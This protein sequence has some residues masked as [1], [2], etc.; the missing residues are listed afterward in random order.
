MKELY[1]RLKL[2]TGVSPQALNNTNT[3]GKYFNTAMHRKLLIVLCGAAMAATKTTKIEM[4]QAT[5]INGTGAKAVTNA[6]ATITA[7]TNVDVATIDLTNVANTDKITING[8][9][10][11]KAAATTVASKEF[12]NAA[13]LVSCVNNASYGVTGIKATAA[14]EVVTVEAGETGEKTITATPTNVAGTIVVATVQAK[15]YVELDVSA[16]DINNGFNFIAAKITTTANT[17]VS[18][19]LL[20]GDSRFEPTQNVAAGTSI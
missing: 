8:V 7:N 13:G 16:Q 17:V 11:T 2:N 5:D 4:L 15:A 9:A 18:A 3:T 12:A 19:V 6:E 1:K 10:F 20:E 14:G